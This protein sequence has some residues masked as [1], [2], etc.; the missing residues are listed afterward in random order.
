M[1]QGLYKLG[2]MTD[3]DSRWQFRLYLTYDIS[4]WLGLDVHDVGEYRRGDGIGR[5]LEPGMV[6]TV[7]PGIY[8]SDN[9][10]K[11]I[12]GRGNIPQEEIDDFMKKAG[13]VIAEYRNT[14]M[15]IEDDVLVTEDGHENL[16]KAAPKEIR[17][18]EKTMKK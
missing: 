12:P 18:I 11:L 5:K 17:E 13:P 16:S 9:T 10:L 1:A 8:I 14:G 6:L 15:R 7:E 3:P 4:H 2:L